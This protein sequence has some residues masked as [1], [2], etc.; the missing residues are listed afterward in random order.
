MDI[1][2]Y[3]TTAQAAVILG[4]N[5]SRVRQLIL[6]GRL[7]TVRVGRDH[8]I[9]PRDLKPLRDRGKGGWPKGRRRKPKC[10]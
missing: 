9:D 2:K 5:T 7:P 8:F 1:S 3:L 4:V 6:A 10:G